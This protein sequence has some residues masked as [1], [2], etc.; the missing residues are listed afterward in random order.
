M[1]LHLVYTETKLFQ[2]ND[3]MQ[4]LNNLM[5]DMENNI[6]FW[7][8]LFH[9]DKLIQLLYVSNRSV[10]LRKMVPYTAVRVRI[11]INFQLCLRMCFCSVHVCEEEISV[12]T[13]PV[14]FH[15]NMYC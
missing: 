1:N 15:R 6:N 2:I 9:V 3:M 14:P 13:I 7:N 10:K 11:C 12:Y 4:Q 8:C 5:R